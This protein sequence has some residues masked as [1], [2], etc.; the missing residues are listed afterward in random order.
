MT[1]LLVKKEAFPAL[2]LAKIV[3][4][5][6]TTLLWLTRANQVTYAQLLLVFALIYLPW[7]AYVNW[8][9][10]GRN[11]LPVFAAVGAMYFLYYAVALFWG[12]LSV[13]ALRLELRQSRSGGR[14]PC[15]VFR[16]FY[17]H[18][19]AGWQAGHD[20]SYLDDPA[21]CVC[22]PF[23]KISPPR[24]KAARQ[25]AYCRLSAAAISLRNV[26]GLAGCLYLHYDYLRLALRG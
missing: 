22:D 3:P 5:V 14:H 9:K 24:G 26:V 2:V 25:G 21:V 23:P 10:G 12:D 15:R 20:H 8:R 17:I 6:V 11:E 7:Q 13:T 18:S 16:S 19:G 4:L 1:K